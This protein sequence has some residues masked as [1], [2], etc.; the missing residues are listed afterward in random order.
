MEL[1]IINGTY[2]EPNLFPKKLQQIRDEKQSLE[3]SLAHEQASQISQLMKRIN[4][5]EAETTNKQN[6]LVNRLLFNIFK[7]IHFTSLLLIGTIETRKNRIGKH[8]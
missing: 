4:R 6:T 8:T 1:A 7:F 2:R 5:L 3:Q